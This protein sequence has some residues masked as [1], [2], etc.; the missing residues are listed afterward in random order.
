MSV[1]RKIYDEFGREIA[2][3]RIDRYEVKVRI[4]SNVRIIPRK[5]I[6]ELARLLGINEKEAIVEICK[7]IR[8][9]VKED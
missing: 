7:L 5:I 6:I 8:D 1:Y 3:V 9:Y 2:T 4:G